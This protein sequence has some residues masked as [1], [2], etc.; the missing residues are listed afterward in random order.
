MIAGVGLDVVDIERVATL[1]TDKGERAL[2]RLFT[3]GERAYCE[4]KAARVR[5]YASRVAAKEAAFKAL[6]GS[7]AARAIGWRE[8]EVCLDAQGRPGV[9]LHGRAAARAKDLGV[10]RVWVTLTHADTVAAAVVI[11]ETGE[12]ARAFPL[13]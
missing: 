12:V 4:G 11:V 13:E 9:V 5:H 2:R 1:L 8:I 7:Q 3:E 10:T 6:S